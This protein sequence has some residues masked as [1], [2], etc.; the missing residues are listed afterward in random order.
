MTH[1]LCLN[2]HLHFTKVAELDEQEVQLYFALF[3]AV[4]DVDWAAEMNSADHPRAASGLHILLV[5][6][7]RKK[8][9]PFDYWP[10]SVKM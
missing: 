3:I 8:N 6:K 9:D 7:K 1:Y 2:L 4:R 5:F 10:E